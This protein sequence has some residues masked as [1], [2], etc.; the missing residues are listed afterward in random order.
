LS[1]TRATRIGGIQLGSNFAL[2]PYRIT[3]PIPAFLGSTTLPSAVDLYVNGMREFNGQVP[4][5]P[6]QLNTIPNIN[7]AGNAQV[8]LTD[9][10][11]RTTT[12]NFSL[13]E[14]HQ[15]LQKGLS[16]WSVELGTVRENY[17]IN[18]F[19]YSHDAAASGTW[20]YG[21]TNDFTLETHGEGTPGL[22]NAG[23]G[24]DWQIGQAGVVSGAMATSSH[25][26]ESGSQFSLG[27]NWVNGRFNFGVNTARTSGDYLDVASL[28]GTSPPRS[29]SNAQI[30]YSTEHFG[31]F[32]LSYIALQYPGQ[33]ASRY[34]SANWFKSL[35]RTTSLSVSV[36][37]D[38]VNHS[39]STVFA[40]LTWAIDAHTTVSA[41]TQHDNGGT[42]YT[43]NASSPTPSEGGFGWSAGL[44]QGEGQNGGQVEVDYLGPYGRIEGGVNDL[45]GNR[46]AYA[47]ATGALVFMDSHLFAARHIDD[48]FAVVSTDGFGGVPVTL[49]NRPIGTTDSNGMLLVVPLNAY[50]NNALAIDP[51]QLPAGVRID[52]VSALATPSDR[53]GTLVTFGITP[54]RAASVLLV[55][56]AGVPLPLGSTVRVNAQSTNPAMVGFD[57]A[58]YLDTLAVQN[59]LRVDT[60][61]GPCHASFDYPKASDGIP[62]IGPLRCIKEASP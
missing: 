30:G 9:V 54:L 44:R 23:A 56:A 28:Y 48:A 10:F 45:S 3:T 14:T 19:D 32:E 2:Q 15:L 35:G 18:S 57:G 13:Y 25:D 51:M 39:Q 20:R 52:R 37:Q 5:G 12:V 42:I 4:A 33:A 62:Q 53:A 34:A 43:A 55:D 29:T 21:V 31:G 50:Q 1:W 49:A 8:V 59:V 16:D 26:G 61:A 11:G 24:A 41:G 17:G 60:P 47:D 22:A 36:N 27:Y 6:F 40:T 7:G 38:L 46:Y 58:V